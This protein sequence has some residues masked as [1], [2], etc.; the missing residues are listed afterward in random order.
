[1]LARDNSYKDQFNSIIFKLFLQETLSR[2]E[3]GN[4]LIKFGQLDG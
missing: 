1:M 3:A 2:E 4:A